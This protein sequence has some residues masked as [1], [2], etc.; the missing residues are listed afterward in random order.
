[1]TVTVVASNTGI[2][3]QTGA[4]KLY[5]D[6][7]TLIAY[8]PAF[9]ALTKP[10]A[11]SFTGTIAQIPI[12]IYGVD[13]IAT[14]QTNA[15][16]SGW[17]SVTADGLTFFCH[18]DRKQAIL[19]VDSANGAITLVDTVTTLTGNTPQTGDNYARIGAA[20]IG[21]TNL[22]DAR[23]ANLDVA[24]SSR[25]SSGAVAA[26]PTA[27]QN[28]QEMDSN[29]TKLAS[30]LAAIGPGSGAFTVTI[31]VNDGVNPIQDAVVSLKINGNLY[32]GLPTNVSGVTTITPTEGNG[33]YNVAIV[34]NE[35]IF[36]Q[37]TLVVS[38]NTS[39]T[40]SMTRR[41]ITPSVPPGVTGYGT[42]ISLVT[43][44]PVAGAIITISGI[45]GPDGTGNM[46]TYGQTS[47][48]SAADGTFAFTDLI[49]GAEIQLRVNSG[50][51]KRF[52]VDTVDF[53]LPNSPAIG[54]LV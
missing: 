16:W 6:V 19:S 5:S 40:Y 33:T 47:A 41:T 22:G 12:G 2:F 21:L 13:L 25:A 31:T 39:H 37:T 15:F 32:S 48:T 1:M 36:T 52:I 34:A 8:N 35:F 44:L 49:V 54:D 45:A 10:G 9:I 27:V 7:N 43:G 18:V 26:I 20:G 23:L 3:G 53:E 28:R 30:I 50:A 24:V 17:V 46:F 42:V 14:G 11:Y 51:W 38:G 29:S 4:V